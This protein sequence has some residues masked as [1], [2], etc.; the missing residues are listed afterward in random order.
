[1]KAPKSVTLLLTL[2][3]LAAGAFA[4]YQHRQAAPLRLQVDRVRAAT[5]AQAAAASKPS[6]AATAPGASLSEPDKLELLR[7]RGEVTR[8]EARRRE[9]AAVKAEN[10]RLKARTPGGAT[11]GAGGI[12]IPAGYV[13]RQDTQNVGSATPEAA[14]Q[15]LF[16]A[17]ER[18]DTNTLIQLL[19]PEVVDDFQRELAR[20]EGE[21]FWKQAR[22]PG[23][24]VVSTTVAGSD[25][26]DVAVL[27]VEIIPG[28]TP[29]EMKAV[30]TNDGWRLAP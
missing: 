30:L 2:V 5:V 21:D 25:S 26:G 10:A 29:H 1:M 28:E 3:A 16:W 7:L 12:P 17:M 18:R 4:W 20:H 14:L 24:R 15:S 19:A 11:G 22:V 27:Q 23:F 6:P 9:L 8:L 13:R